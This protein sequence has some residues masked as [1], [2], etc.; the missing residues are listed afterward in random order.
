[1]SEHKALV[2]WKFSGT[3]YL[4]GKYS[5]EHTW[6]FDGGAVVPASASPS[7]VPVPLSNPANV[8]PEE[9]FVASLSSCHLLTYLFVAQKQGFQ[10]ESYDDEAV[11]MLSKN[12][13][14]AIWVSKVTLAP[15]I[16][17]AGDKRPTPEE[18]DRLHHAA[19]R[20]CFIA[21]SVKTEVVV[22]PRRG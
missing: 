15:K 6:R 1:M 10:I 22:Q 11:G 8:D 16:V 17:Y 4:K 13:R 21:N 7:V 2:S 19:H 20:D 14:G 5:R 3:D 9:A 12:E 18:E